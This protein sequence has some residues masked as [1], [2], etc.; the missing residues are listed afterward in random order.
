MS[1][2]KPF[3]VACYIG[4]SMYHHFCDFLNLYATLHLNGSFSRNVQIVAWDTSGGNYY[5]L[6][7]ETWQAFT[8][9]PVIFIKEFDGKKICFRDAVFSLLARMRYG[10]YYNTPLVPNCHGS[11]L[12]HAFSSY[13][14]EKLNISQNGPLRKK[15]RITLLTRSTKHRRILNEN[16][17]NIFIFIVVLFRLMKFS[18]QLKITHNTDIF[19]GMHGSG[20]THLLFLPYWASVFEVYDCG[21]KYCYSDLARLKGVKYFTW[22]TMHKMK[23][24]NQGKHPTIG[25]HAKFTNYT[26]DV[27][28]FSRI[29]SKAAD[30]VRNNQEFQHLVQSKHDKMADRPG[31]LTRLFNLFVQSLKPS[32]ERVV[33]GKDQ[34]GNVYYVEKALYERA[35]TG[36][37][38]YLPG[39]RADWKQIPTEWEMWLK[40][41]RKEVPTQEEIDFNYQRMMSVKEKAAR[42]EDQALREKLAAKVGEAE[43]AKQLSTDDNQREK[44]DFSKIPTIKADT[45]NEPAP[46]PSYKEYENFP[47]HKYTGYQPKRN[48]PK[49]KDS[50]DS[51]K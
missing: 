2:S 23:R 43:E 12:F 22:Q 49:N 15:I 20:L 4:V 39:N 3:L 41:A 46:F 19:I 6:F 37:R 32:C 24:Q 50:K 29:V 44:R 34:F 11:G 5:D 28:E 30:Y 14:L 40:Y 45:P 48:D 36:T 9:K 21:D 47:G 27:V 51:D 42:L 38:G 35:K 26:F 7:A 17:V 8:N 18:D 25:S 1:W 13:I 16:E 33:V 10:L 31:V